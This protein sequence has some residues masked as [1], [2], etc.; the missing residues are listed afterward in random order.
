MK[1]VQFHYEKKYIKDFLKLPKLLYSKENNMEDP[2][3]I[4]NIL[5]GK[6]VLMKYIDEL[7]KFIIYDNDNNPVARYAITTYKG[8]EDVCYIGFFE[9]VKDEL[10]AEFAFMEADI[11]AEVHGYKEIVGPVDLGMWHK[12]RLKIDNFDKRPYTG[13]PYNKDYYY[14]MFTDN[15]YVIKDKYTSD[16]YD[17]LEEAFS[18]D[19]IKKRYDYFIEK[20][21]EFKS[22]TIDTWDKCIEEVY[23]L[24]MKLYGSFNTFVKLEKDDF[25]GIFGSYKKILNF[26]MVKIA[27][28]EGKAVGFVIGIPNYNNRVYHLN[29]L[30]N[31]V[32]ILRIK[33]NCKDYLITYMGVDEGHKG[34]ARALSQLLLV[35]LSKKDATFVGALIREGTA[36]SGIVKEV[37][38]FKYN[39]VLMNKK[40]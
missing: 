23:E 34:L 24:I 4:E 35:E 22:P 18:I 27:Y 10:V 33:K 8:E 6:H 17:K 3:E 40:L 11:W 19:R 30:K 5:L 16:S 20:G 32:D 2:G 29:N 36:T 28:Y 9:C 1:C 25:I 21:Y 14:R 13:E 26:E 37:L 7:Y 39:Y 38:N 12:Y 15:G 31:I